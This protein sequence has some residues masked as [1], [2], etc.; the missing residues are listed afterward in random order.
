MPAA[1]VYVE[2]KKNNTETRVARTIAS[3]LSNKSETGIEIPRIGLGSAEYYD[4]A[5]DIIDEYYD[6][7]II[8]LHEIDMVDNAEALLHELSRARE[9]GHTDAYI[10]II[11]TCGRL[12]RHHRDQQRHRLRPNNST[13]GYKARCP[14][15]TSSLNPIK[16][17]RSSKSW[18]TVATRSRTASSKT[19]SSKKPPIGPPTNTVRPESCRRPPDCR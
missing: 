15:L 6:D 5:Y 2:C 3:A 8:I 4:Y 10:G 7:L 18:R 17:T 11:A 13:R 19:A 16:A 9:A 1:G 14:R 12:H